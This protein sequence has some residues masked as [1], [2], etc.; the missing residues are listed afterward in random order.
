MSYFAMKVMPVLNPKLV[1]LSS[2]MGGFLTGTI[3]FRCFL[4]KIPRRYIVKC[5]QKFLI[6][7]VLLS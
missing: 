6:I 3:F 7:S 2:L 5:N 4:M 1:I